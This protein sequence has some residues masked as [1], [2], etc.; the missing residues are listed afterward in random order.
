MIPVLYEQS[1]N[2]FMSNGIGRLS[3]CMTGTVSERLNEFDTLELTYPA[4]GEY[5]EEL[6]AGRLILA[7]PAEGETPQPFRIREVDRTLEGVVTVYADHISYDL[8]GYP[9]APFTASSASDA[10]GKLSSS[11][12]VAS[13]FNFSTDITGSGSFTVGEPISI[14]EALG[15]DKSIL[16]TYGG[17]LKFNRYDVQLLQARGSDRGV[18]IRHGK[19]MTELTVTSGMD[20]YYTGAIAYYEKD[21]SVVRSAVQYGNSSERP[22]RIL[23]TDHSQDFDST[24][25]TAQLNTLAAADLA[26]TSGKLYSV[27]ASFAPL[28]QSDEYAAEA[29]EER[30]SLGDL[31]R[32]VHEGY[33]IDRKMKVVETVFNFITERYESI[34]LGEI[35]PTLAD[36]LAGELS[37]EKGSG[38]EFATRII[39]W[40]DNL[41]IAAGAGA[42]VTGSAPSATYN[43]NGTT[44]RLVTDTPIMIRVSSATTDGANSSYVIASAGRPTGC[45]LRNV[46]SSAAKIKVQ[47]Y[48]LYRRA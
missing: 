7:L 21:G 24:P 32:V 22:Q 6:V 4:T 34:E 8:A 37:G 31:V 5:S 48:F 9:V 29:L 45:Y 14:R 46:H 12:I 39:T 33:Q 27:T 16:S 25:T 13:G 41:S 30:V 19:N 44:Y 18:T 2:K 47:G 3:D 1:E 10:M 15:G 42:S 11:A 28:W 35:R 36:K 23:I 26:A 38:A 17:E 43:L 20:G 40:K